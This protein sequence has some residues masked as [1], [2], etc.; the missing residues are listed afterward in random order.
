M[1]VWPQEGESRAGWHVGFSIGEGVVVRPRPREPGLRSD[2]D[3]DHSRS[4]RD[5][6]RRPTPRT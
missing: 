1:T 2:A 5:Y 6:G 3:E 4:E